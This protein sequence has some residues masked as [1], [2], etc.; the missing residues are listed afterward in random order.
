MK[1]ISCVTSSRGVPY[2]QRVAAK[3][4]D[5]LHRRS[6]YG[7]R[8]VRKALIFKDKSICGDQPSLVMAPT[9]AQKSAVKYRSRRRQMHKV[10]QPL[11]R[12]LNWMPSGPGWLERNRY[13]SDESVARI[14]S[15][16]SAVERAV[17]QI[18]TGERRGWT[19]GRGTASL[20]VFVGIRGAGRSI[21]RRG[22]VWRQGKGTR[23]EPGRFAGRHMSSSMFARF[24]SWISGLASMDR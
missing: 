24:V 10:Q 3:Q 8:Q 12:T 18:D 5:R 14:M 6:D 7:R 13:R 4:V 16:H 9:Y 20:S 15:C 1:L 17:Y 19:S 11:H 2:A 22:E 23:F 21:E